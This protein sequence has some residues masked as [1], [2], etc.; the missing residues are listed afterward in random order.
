[1]LFS[2]CKTLGEL[3]IKPSS[4]E[5]VMALKNILDSSTFKA[6]KK[7]K[8][9]DDDG[10]EKAL[11]SEVEIVLNSLK[12]VG[13]GDEV[14]KMPKSNSQVSTLALGESEEIIG[15][16]IGELK[17]TDAAAVVLGG[18]DAAT[19]VLKRAM[20]ITVKKRYSARLGEELDKTDVNT[21]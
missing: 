10:L 3:G 11:P 9:I 13:Y 21:Y 7:L 8:N 17:F 20:Y 16:A 18:E 19:N 1:M 14:E 12:T 5:T 15:H 2:S 6:I 4:L